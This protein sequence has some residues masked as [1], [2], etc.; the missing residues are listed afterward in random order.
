MPYLVYEAKSELPA[1]QFADS[2]RPFVGR[3]NWL[4]VPPRDS[5]PFFGTVGSTRFRIM[6]VIRGRDSFN[7]VLYGRF[8]SDNHGTRVRVVMTLHP[9]VRAF[10]AIWSFFTSRYAILAIRDHFPADFY[11]GLGFLL[12]AWLMAVPVFYY[13]AA[14]SKRL[15]RESLHLQD[16]A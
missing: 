5:V 1:N 10:L 4:G 13:D 3:P 9:F 15:L 2:L 11:G 7:P 12:F 14:K 8:L 16:A 6:R